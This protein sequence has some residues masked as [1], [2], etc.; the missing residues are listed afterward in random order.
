MAVTRNWFQTLLLPVAALVACSKAGFVLLGHA[1]TTGLSVGGDWLGVIFDI[2][3]A[4]V[5]IGKLDFWDLRSGCVKCVRPCCKI[6]ACSLRNVIFLIMWSRIRRGG[7]TFACWVD[8]LVEDT[9][10]WPII[11]S[12]IAVGV[13]FDF[14]VSLCGK[15][16]HVGNDQLRFNFGV[17][18]IIIRGVTIG[19]AIVTCGNGLIGRV[20]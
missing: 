18:V 1:L 2:G 12:V 6:R 16:S 5:L 7:V 11:E 9:G 4:R 3:V 15:G 17:G 14:W 13:K 8:W 19:I 10:R 20:G